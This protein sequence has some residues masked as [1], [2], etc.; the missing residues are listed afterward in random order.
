M[1]SRLRGARRRGSAGGRT[2]PGAT[3][4]VVWRTL[5]QENKVIPPVLA[6][7]ALLVFSWVVAG[8]F[9]GGT[10]E[11]ANSGEVASSD[12]GGEVAQSEGNDAASPPPSEI[13]SPNAESFAAYESKDPFR[14]LFTPASAD[15]GTAQDTPGTSG[16]DPADADPANGGS[17]NGGSAN[18]DS[19]GATESE[20]RGG[21]GN[22]GPRQD[23]TSAPDGNNATANQ[24]GN[25]ESSVGQSRPGSA[26][27]GKS[28][29]SADGGSADGG[30]ADGGSADGGSAGGSGAGGSANG[31]S[32]SGGNSGTGYLYD[33]GGNLPSR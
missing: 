29:G 13:E 5:I 28:G 27:G 19:R 1:L 10:D 7:I 21:N 9:V 24:Y 26:G 3:F 31:G 25:D 30:S 33:S 22:D 8:T 14:S 4:A 12:G 17:A 16:G 11:S 23:T 6:V 2:S 15:D 32:G 18:G 20:N